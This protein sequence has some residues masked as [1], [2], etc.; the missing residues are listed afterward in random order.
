MENEA[1]AIAKLCVHRHDN[2]VQVVAHG[3]VPGF[4]YYFIDMEL[5]DIDLASYLDT[6]CGRDDNVLTH[7]IALNETKCWE[8]LNDITSGLI[9]IHKRKEIHRDLKPRNSMLVYINR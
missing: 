5:C 1:R 8:I 4:P 9:F 7:P 6:K 3:K 2:I